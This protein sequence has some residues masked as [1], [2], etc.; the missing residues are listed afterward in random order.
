VCAIANVY[1]RFGARG[2]CRARS[3]ADSMKLV[4]SPVI[5][6][7]SAQIPITAVGDAV[8]QFVGCS[9]VTAAHPAAC[10]ARTIASRASTTVPPRNVREKSACGVRLARTRISMKQPCDGVAHSNR[11]FERVRRQVQQIARILPCCLRP[12]T[13]T[14]SSSL[15]SNAETLV[16]SQSSGSRTEMLFNVTASSV[17]SESLPGASEIID[18]SLSTVHSGKS[19][20]PSGTF[21]ARAIC[22]QSLSNRTPLA[23][24]PP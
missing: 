21:A 22:L 2:Q 20:N 16:V 18:G 8:L 9:I 3:F 23:S 17:G 14:V 15:H 7:Q 6:A 1:S 19:S 12:E 13:A 10:L 4:A 24:R 5:G 11:S